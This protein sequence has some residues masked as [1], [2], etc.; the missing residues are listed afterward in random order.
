MD[1]FDIADAAWK[2]RSCSCMLRAWTA[3]PCLS[4]P[5]SQKTKGRNWLSSWMLVNRDGWASS[6]QDLV[7]RRT[8]DVPT[9]I[10][11]ECERG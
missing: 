2:C 3:C 5:T 11:L 8:C 1:S 10:G 6:L 9:F 4:W 7:A